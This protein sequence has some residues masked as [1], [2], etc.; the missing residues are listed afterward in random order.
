MFLTK[1]EIIPRRNPQTCQGKKFLLRL[2]SAVPSWGEYCGSG[3][4]EDE[5][6][7]LASDIEMWQEGGYFSCHVIIYI[8]CFSLIISYLFSNKVFILNRGSY[9][10]R[11]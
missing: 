9:S 1:P 3:V 10:D 5:L 2:V 11:I 7:S 8:E 4:A 6:K